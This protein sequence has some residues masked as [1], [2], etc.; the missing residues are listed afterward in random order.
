[1][2]YE[3]LNLALLEARA[4]QK[5]TDDW[6]KL[7]PDPPSDMSEQTKRELNQVKKMA[8]NRSPEE[9]ELVKRIDDDPAAT[10]RDVVKKHG[11]EYPKAEFDKAYKA[12][13]PIILKLKR[14]FK[15]PRPYALDKS[16]KYV[17]SETHKYMAYPSG[18]V[19]FAALAEKIL[20]MKYPSHS[21][22]F[23]SALKDVG[24]AR[25]LM[26]VHYPSDNTA[27]EKLVDKLWPTLKKEIT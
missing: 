14:H 22:E 4:A 19:A 6:A 21:A 18:H 2:L 24:R 27:G 17:P 1:M 11:L 13:Q 26:G 5:V 3:R 9:L 10:L 7:L 25:M 8:N 12:L 16:I 23:K 20:S 15:R